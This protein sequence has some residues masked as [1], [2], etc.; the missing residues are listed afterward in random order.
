MCAVKLKD[1]QGGLTQ[2]WYPEYMPKHAG[3]HIKK[4]I[5]GVIR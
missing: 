1:G 2:K 5:G 3:A 4:Q